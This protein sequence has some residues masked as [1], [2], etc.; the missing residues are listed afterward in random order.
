MHVTYREFPCHHVNNNDHFMYTLSI[1]VIIISVAV[2][3][4]SVGIHNTFREYTV[5]HWKVCPRVSK[6]CTCTLGSKQK[7]VYIF[8]LGILGAFQTFKYISFFVLSCEC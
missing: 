7:H 5:C 4:H 2:C 1:L 6:K 8:T 3:I